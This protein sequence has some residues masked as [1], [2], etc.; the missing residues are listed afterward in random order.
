MKLILIGSTQ[1][2]NF[3]P[4]IYVAFIIQRLLYRIYCVLEKSLRYKNARKTTAWLSRF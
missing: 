3:F 4:R 1:F 2:G